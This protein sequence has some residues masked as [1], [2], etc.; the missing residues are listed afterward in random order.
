MEPVPTQTAYADSDQIIKAPISKKKLAIT[1]GLTVIGVILIGAASWFFWLVPNQE[2]AQLEKDIKAIAEAFNKNDLDGALVYADSRLVEHPNNAYLL[3]AKASVLAQKGSLSF[4]EEEFGSQA[5]AVALQAIASD[6]ESSEAYR[7][8]AYA[9]EIQEKY[10]EAHENYAKAIS[11]DSNNA[12][13]HFGNAHSYDLEGDMKKAEEGYKAAVAVDQNF[14]QAYAGLGRIALAKGDNTTAIELYKK[15][16]A[17]TPSVQSKAGAAYTLSNLMRLQGN[18]VEAKKYA[19]EATTLSPEY[20][21]GWYGLGMAYMVEVPTI[22]GNS[23]AQSALIQGAIT[24]FNKVIRLN[25][26]QSLAHLELA[27]IQ[28]SFDQFD[29][30][31][32]SLEGAERS[33]KVDIT[34]N[35]SAKETVQKGITQ[36]REKVV[37][38]QK[39]KAAVPAS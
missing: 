21:L 34:L 13:A 30:A 15:H 38:A 2:Q 1:G 3:T 4:K 28:Y 14:D 31:L 33:A 17:L 6:P 25:P 7:V 16:Y 10:K 37:A 18:V 32:K 5:I 12:S 26:D 24:S 19:T 39:A 29:L 22:K 36:L 9:Y 8:L 11:L 27:R 23:E 35:V 20:P